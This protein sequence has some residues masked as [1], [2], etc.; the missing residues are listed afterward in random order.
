MSLGP[1]AHEWE[2]T[3]QRRR[4]LLTEVDEYWQIR[5][6]HADDPQP[7]A[8]PTRMSRLRDG[9]LNGLA[10]VSGGPIQFG[11]RT[12]NPT[13]RGSIETPGARHRQ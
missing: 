8:A 4:E 6:A 2:V 13:M 5:N 11:P 7:E 10:R 9:I 12:F 3:E 1:Y